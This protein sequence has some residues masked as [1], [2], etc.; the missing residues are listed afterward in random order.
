MLK[1]ENYFLIRYIFNN[2]L[3]DRGRGK[4]RSEKGRSKSLA[5][6]LKKQRSEHAAVN[7]SEL[8]KVN[9]LAV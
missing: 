6:P 3:N 8:N 4:T 1:A 9:K 7:E 5:N 2:K